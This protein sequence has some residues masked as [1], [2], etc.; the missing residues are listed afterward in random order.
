MRK[1]EIWHVGLPEGKG[2]EQKG[3]RPAI[4][5]GYANGMVT[6]VPL[7]T[8]SPNK[9]KLAF[10]YY[11]EADKENKLMEDSYALIFQMTALDGSRLISRLGI[12]DKPKQD[13]VDA[14]IKSLFKL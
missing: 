3:N 2:H 11:V 1:G 8:A 13:A 10:T 12:I 9:A 6:V 4:V 14:I 7:T 5:M